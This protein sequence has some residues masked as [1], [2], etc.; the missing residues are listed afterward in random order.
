MEN[1]WLKHVMQ[2]KKLYGAG[3]TYKEILKE[4]RKSYVPLPRSGR[5]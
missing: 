5:R 4:A 3:M 1:P 2:W